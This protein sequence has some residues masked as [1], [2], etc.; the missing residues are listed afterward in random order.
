MVSINFQVDDRPS[1]LSNFQNPPICAG[2]TQLKNG[3]NWDMGKQ[4][5]F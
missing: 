2:S 4:K 5:V 3:K 1:S